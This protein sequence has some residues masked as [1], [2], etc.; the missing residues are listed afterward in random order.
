MTVLTEKI[1][2][3]ILS[4]LEKSINNLATSTFDNLEFDEGFQGAENFLQ[5]QFDIRLE[6]VLVSKSSSIHHLESGM[7]NKIIQRKQMI[8]SEISK[9]YKN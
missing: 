4:Q 8:F 7:K 9:Q 6:N 3:E 5:T 2:E 1:L